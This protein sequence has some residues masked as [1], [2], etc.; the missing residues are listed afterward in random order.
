[1]THMEKDKLLSSEE[2]CKI[3]KISR[4][5][6][7]RWIKDGKVESIKIGKRHLFK[8]SVLEQ[9]IKGDSR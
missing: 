6:L 7:Y 5:T 2:I 8:E 3:L 1:M 4:V 9:L